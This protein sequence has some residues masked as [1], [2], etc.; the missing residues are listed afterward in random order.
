MLLEIAAI[1]D[2]GAIIRAM[3]FSLEC[4]TRACALPM[5]MGMH[6]GGFREAQDPLAAERVME[7]GLV[8]SKAGIRD[9]IEEWLAPHDVTLHLCANF[10]THALQ[11]SVCWR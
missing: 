8:Q 3:L 11:R 4:L 10:Y 5:L 2:I 7:E 9:K 6:K 1:K